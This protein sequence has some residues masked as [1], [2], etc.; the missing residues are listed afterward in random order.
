[1]GVCDDEE[2]KVPIET[3]KVEREERVK[4][5][6]TGGGEGCSSR[7]HR[8]RRT[9]RTGRGRSTYVLTPGYKYW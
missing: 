7:T 5:G 2:P 4:V 6:A 8:K 9:E 1:M 3:E